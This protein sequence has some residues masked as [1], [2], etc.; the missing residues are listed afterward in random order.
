MGVGFTAHEVIPTFTL[1]DIIDILPG[2]I[3]NNVL[4][5]KKH[6]NGVSISY[7]DAYTRSILSIF[8]KEDIIEAAYEMLVWCVKNGY[9]KKQIIKTSHEKRNADSYVNDVHIGCKWKYISI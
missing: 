9:V 6:V 2:S 8:E 7:E 5:I 3:D 1:Q 4:T